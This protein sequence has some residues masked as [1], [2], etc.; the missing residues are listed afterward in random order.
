MVEDSKQHSPVER[1][2]LRLQRIQRKAKRTGAKKKNQ[3]KTKHKIQEKKKKK[4][5]LSSN[6]K[7]AKCI[8]TTPTK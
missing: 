8:P 7:R 3:K 2:K 6:N 1:P 4:A 5:F